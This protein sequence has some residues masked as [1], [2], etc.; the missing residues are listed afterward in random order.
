MAGI[1]TV[2]TGAGLVHSCLLM[3]DH[4]PS[5]PRH[6]PLLG[7]AILFAGLAIVSLAL[8]LVQSF[9]GNTSLAPLG[10]PLVWL[11]GLD[12][13]AALDTL[14]NAAEVVAAVLA[15][16][17]TVVAIVVELAATRYSHQITTLFLR[18][19]VN[20]LVPGLFV[21]TTVQC[22][23]VAAVL[24]ESGPAALVP[25]A[26]FAITLG[27]VT[28]CLLL[29]VPYIYFVFTFLS[30]I[31]VIERICRDAYRMVIRVKPGTVDRHQHR[32]EEAIDELQDVARSAIAQGDRGI[33]MAAVD[34]L[35]GFVF[36]YVR[37]RPQLPVGWFDVTP[38]VAR[39]PDFFAL[40]PETMS[41]VR[42]QGIWLERKVF[43]R[44]LSLMIQCALNSRDVANL[45]GI[46]TQR[47]ASDLG[48][49]F[50][51]L[52]E[53][54]LRTFN[55]YLRVTIGARDA[56]T[57]YFL[58]NQYR[59]IGERLLQEGQADEAVAI[60]RY[61][62]EYGQLAHNMGLSFLLE[63]AAYDVMQMVEDAMDL[64][65]P[66]VDPLLDTLLQLDQE[67]KEESQEDS[68][69]GV[70][71]SQ[72][73]L[74]TLFLQRGDEVRFQRIVDD[75]R[76]ER[77]ERLERLKQGLLTDDRPQFWE[78]MDRGVNFSYLLPERRQFLEPLFEA[79]ARPQ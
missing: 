42:A 32:V 55:S 23:W 43:R 16:A 36:D 15:I 33:A 18:E 4:T 61:L 56:R 73:Q 54:C 3:A 51:D 79:L 62:R 44:Y 71:R 68:L 21:L 53:L 20:L 47:I 9:L 17:I 50:P 27:L 58:M 38:S 12:T 10:H 13:S 45:I 63:T 59:I 31:S 8:L 28:L 69:L 40:A 29:L 39:D 78:L 60:S 77:L 22:V 75:L 7:P 76:E 11:A 74:A 14:S 25:Q 46:N 64:N 2:G 72:I 19:P 24:D 66:A 30:P 57:A 48:P 5:I 6:R 1:F 65:S 37:I 26:G 70:R 41:E 52:L 49:G 35:A 34:A 67:I